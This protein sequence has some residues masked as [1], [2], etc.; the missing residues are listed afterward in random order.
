MSLVAVTALFGLYGILFIEFI[1]A[2]R[3]RLGIVTYALIALAVLPLPFLLPSVF[4]L[5][6]GFNIAQASIGGLT[7]YVTFLYLSSSIYEY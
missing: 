3:K 1:K 2:Y 7:Q 4:N 5:Y 6:M